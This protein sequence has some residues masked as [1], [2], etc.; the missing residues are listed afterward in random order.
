MSLLLDTHILLWAVSD[1]ARLTEDTRARLDDPAE[2]LVFS[3]ASLWEIAIKSALGRDDFRVD[4]ARLRAACLA[5]G[6]LELPVTGLH[7]LGV[8]DLP[9]I[10]RDPFD[11]ILVAQARAERLPLL[12]ADSAV[13][14]YGTP[15]ESVRLA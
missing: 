2:T 4:G 1:A 10:H 12:T 14:A 13:A 6:Y 9:P 3:A 7:A 5:A 11:R 8:A 15:V